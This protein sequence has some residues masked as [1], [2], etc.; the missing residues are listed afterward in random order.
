MLYVDGGALKFD[1]YVVLSRMQCIDLTVLLQRYTYEMCRMLLSGK[2]YKANGLS[3]HPTNHICAVIV[4]CMH[5]WIHNVFALDYQMRK[6]LCHINIGLWSTL[7]YAHALFA[8]NLK[9][10]SASNPK[11]PALLC[12]G[13]PNISFFILSVCW[14]RFLVEIVWRRWFQEI[15]NLAITK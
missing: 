2:T 3:I 13:N 12:H 14:Q 7:S 8:S 9:V 5:A 15:S 11:H 6:N 4:A 1:I 10:I